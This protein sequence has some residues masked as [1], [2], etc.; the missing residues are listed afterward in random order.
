[1]YWFKF[2]T[3]PSVIFNG[4]PLRWNLSFWPCR[5]SK[6]LKF[7][8]KLVVFK[9]TLNQLTDSK[10]VYN[11]SVVTLPP[12]LARDV[13]EHCFKFIWNFQLAKVKRNN[14]VQ[15]DCFKKN[16][17]SSFKKQPGSLSRAWWHVNS[18]LAQGAEIWTK[19]FIFIPSHAHVFSIKEQE[20][21]KK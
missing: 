7:T 8:H 1:M 9:K 5:N 16:R 17:P 15:C 10:L 4:P 6:K 21:C 12:N 19:Q 11:A 14:V 3:T 18:I 13:D 20:S 2:F